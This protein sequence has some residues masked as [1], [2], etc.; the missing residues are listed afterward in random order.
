MVLGQLFEVAIPDLFSRIFI[1][2]I[3]SDLHVDSGHEGFVKAAHAIG[4]QEKNTLEIVEGSQ[5][6]WDT[7]VSL[8]C[9]RL[10]ECL[11]ETMLLRRR[12]GGDGVSR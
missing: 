9:R 2:W 1:E 5:K 8:L 7:L 10:D 4:R 3:V 12:S 6:D 11:L